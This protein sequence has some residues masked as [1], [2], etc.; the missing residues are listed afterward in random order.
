MSTVSAWRSA[1]K[2]RHSA[3]S[4]I[5]TQRKIAPSKVA[6]MEIARRLDAGNDAHGF[7]LLILALLHLGAPPSAC[8]RFRSIPPII[9][10]T[11]K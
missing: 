7:D 4:C 9:Q 8:D 11:A 10:A 3:S 1:R 6:E 2:N 5:R